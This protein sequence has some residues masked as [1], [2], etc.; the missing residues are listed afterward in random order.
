MSEEIIQSGV[1]PK[2]E[3]PIIEFRGVSKTYKSGTHALEDI[4]I[5][6]GSGST[7]RSFG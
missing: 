6:I 7:Y 2:P 1:N 4:N 3:K 5:R